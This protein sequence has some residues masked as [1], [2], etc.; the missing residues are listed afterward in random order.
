[1][2][3]GSHGISE[4]LEGRKST[5]LVEYARGENRTLSATVARLHR[6][7]FFEFAQSQWLELV[8]FKVRQCSAMCD[9]FCKGSIIMNLAVPGSIKSFIGPVQL[10]RSALVPKMMRA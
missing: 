2:D 8:E 10:Q 3:D 9:I 4:P 6:L 7:T 1:M 5:Y